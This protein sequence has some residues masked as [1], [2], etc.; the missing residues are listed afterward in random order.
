MAIRVGGAALSSETW[1]SVVRP[2][3]QGVAQSLGLGFGQFTVQ[4]LLLGEGDEV[5]GQA[6][7]L[8][9]A[10]VVVEVG[11]RQVAQPG[12]F[13]AADAVL[14]SGVTTVAGFEILDVGVDRVGD[15]D[16]VAPTTGVKEVELGPIVGLFT[17]DDGPSADGP[18]GQV[19][20]AQLSHVGPFADLTVCRD[21]L[22]PR[23]GW[24]GQ[25]GQ[26][27]GLSHL[28]T[29]GELDAPLHQRVDKAMAGPGAVRPHLN[30]ATPPVGSMPSGATGSW[31]K[32]SSSTSMWSS[33]SWAAALPGRSSMASA[34]LVAS[35]KQARG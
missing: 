12:V 30:M 21:G 19:E 1:W 8:H 24:K 9:P 27:N 25:Y 35:Q 22:G 18:A 4:H 34:S 11:K 13:G 20:V 31:A 26:A 5:L 3:E 28:E 17:S 10:G 15:E 6:D 7:Q 23:C 29:N 14:D 32:A 2:H 33:T 16:L